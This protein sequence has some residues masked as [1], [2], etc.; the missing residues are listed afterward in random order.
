SDLRNVP[1]P[2]LSANCLRPCIV[3]H[4]NDLD[5]GVQLLPTQDRIALYDV[6]VSCK[7]LGGGKHGQH[8][9][10]PSW[11][12]IWKITTATTEGQRK[13]PKSQERV[14]LRWC[15]TSSLREKTFYGVCAWTWW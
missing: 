15:R 2:K 9:G 1:Y 10:T 12:R 11:S 3:T 8:F 4:Q 13:W 5:L 7:G 14:R 6:D